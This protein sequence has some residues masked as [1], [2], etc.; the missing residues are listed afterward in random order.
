MGFR[1]RALPVTPFQPLF[2]LAD[3][4]LHQLGVL[5]MQAEADFPCRVSLRD[6]TPG[7]TVL[8]LSYEHQPAPTPY[9]SSGPIFVRENADEASFDTDEIPTEMRGRLF[10]ARAYDERGMMIDADVIEGREIEKL[11]GQVFENE[12]VS[13]IHLH[14]ARRGCYACRVDRA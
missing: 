8:L 7:E 1:L 3:N 6:A 12:N 10:S 13:Y 14:H 4:A 2:A 11:I 9:R 5:R